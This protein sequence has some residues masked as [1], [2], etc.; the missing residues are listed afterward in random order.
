MQYMISPMNLTERQLLIYNVLYR[1]CNFANMEASITIEGIITSIKI[2][3]LTYKKVYSDIKVMEK[4]GYIQTI[5]KASKGTAPVYKIVKIEELGYQKKTKGYQK[6][7]KTE[8]LQGLDNDVGYQKK[9]KG[10]QKS[11]NSNDNDKD[12]NIYSRIIDHLNEK[13]SKSF[14]YTTKKTKSCIDARIGEGFTEADFLK[15]IDI[16][17]EEWKDNPDMSKYLRPETLFGT[18]FEGYLQQE[19]VKEQPEQQFKSLY[20]ANKL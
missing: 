2:V 5:R 16:K 4:K 19:T 14:K 13:A 18:K 11:T 9:T 17:T 8:Q 12:N 10:Y 7:T 6:K 1:R 20:G 3:D 15:V